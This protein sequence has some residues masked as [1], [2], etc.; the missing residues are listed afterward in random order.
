VAQAENTYK[1]F[2]AQEI[3]CSDTKA[4]S[5]TA[6]KTQHLLLLIQSALLPTEETTCLRH[7]MKGALCTPW[8]A[9]GACTSVAC[10]FEHAF[11]ES[12][13]RISNHLYRYQCFTS[14]AMVLRIQNTELKFSSFS[15]AWGHLSV[16]FAIEKPAA[17]V[18]PPT[19]E[20]L[21]PMNVAGNSVSKACRTSY[22]S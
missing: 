19:S 11:F 16:G 6:S 22:K 15:H 10:I 3:I 2:R 17:W 7:P 1:T 18:H 21:S 8:C 14:V 12:L 5:G 20:Q 13:H 9:K 4:S